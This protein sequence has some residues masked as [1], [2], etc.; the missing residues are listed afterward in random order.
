M[1]A[2]QLN[3]FPPPPRTYA[4]T[5]DDYG[6]A[7]YTAPSAGKARAKA[8]RDFCDAIARKTFHEFLVMSRV[9]RADSTGGAAWS[10]PKL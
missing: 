5:V 9:R 8:Y 2:R 4:V 7:H 1:M 6:E 3:L 10:T